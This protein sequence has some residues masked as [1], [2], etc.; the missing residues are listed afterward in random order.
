MWA[1]DD[2]CTA[3]SR[4]KGDRR[5][6]LVDR[7]SSS[8]GNL[9]SL[10]RQW[11]DR[12]RFSG[13]THLPPSIR[14]HARERRKVD[15]IRDRDRIANK[16]RLAR[17]KGAELQKHILTTRTDNI[18][19][20]RVQP[21]IFSDRAP[22]QPRVKNLSSARFFFEG[23]PTAAWDGVEEA[24]GGACDSETAKCQSRCSSLSFSTR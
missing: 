15:H 8:L 11:F 3:G 20:S 22:F 1:K 12:P 10:A 9:L 6:V 23:A 16:V 4:I 13:L 17:R 14:G 7:F 5:M 21:S 24:A 18:R 2:N 19:K